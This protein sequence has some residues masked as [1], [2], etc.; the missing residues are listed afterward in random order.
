M[1]RASVSHLVSVKLLKD[2]HSASTRNFLYIL[3]LDIL[4]STCG[5]DYVT[6]W[7]KRP[8]VCAWLCLYHLPDGRR[9]ADAEWMKIHWQII[10]MSYVSLNCQ[11]GWFLYA[12]RIHLWYLQNLAE[13]ES[14][15]NV[16]VWSL[17][18]LGFQKSRFPFPAYLIFSALLELWILQLWSHHCPVRRP[19]VVLSVLEW[20]VDVSTGR[21]GGLFFQI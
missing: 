15:S 11:T 6:M 2:W 13:S 7:G 8:E 5:S 17:L 1:F 20:S 9:G 4:S 12:H 16:V 21:A 19:L 14:D 18:P 3:K 10:L